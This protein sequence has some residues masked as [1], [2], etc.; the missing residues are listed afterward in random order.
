MKVEDVFINVGDYSTQ[1]YIDYA[2]AVTVSRAL[3]YVHDGLKPVHRRILYAMLGLGIKAKEKPKKSARI[4]GDVIGKYHPHGDG[5]VY[6]AMVGMAQDWN[7]RYPLVASQGNFGS[8]DGDGAAAMR[9]TEAG[10][11]PYAEEVLLSEIR[12]GTSDFTP[13]FDGSLTEVVLLSSKLNNLLLNGTFGIAVGMA[14]KIP[15]HNIRN[16][17]DATMAYI[18]NKDITIPE[19]VEHLQAPDFATGGQ[20]ITPKNKIIEAYETGR[21]A[22][23]IRCRWSVEKLPRGQWR[24]VVYELPPNQDVVKVLKTVDKITNPPVT[25]DKQGK[26]K[27]L[28]PNVLKDK[29]FLTSILSDATNQSDKDSLRLVL[30]PKSSK[31]DP[32]EFMS[33]LYARLG[34]EESFNFNLTMVDIN[35]TPQTMNI[36][37]IIA[38]W[39]EYRKIVVR[40]RLNFHLDKALR[41][42]HILEG[43]L[44]V[45]FNIDKAI[46]IIRTSEEPKEDLIEAFELSDIQAED[47]L[48][49]K[50]RQLA[51]L[52]KDKLEKEHAKLEA[53]KE[54]LQKILASEARFMTLIKKEIEET[55]K[56][57]EDDR[58]TIVEEAQEAIA[59]SSD[60][61]I[62]EPVTAIYTKYG[63]LTLRKGHGVD[64]STIALKDGDA[65]DKIIEGKTTDKLGFLATDGRGY[66]IKMIEVP[67]GKN[68]VHIKSLVDCGD[69]NIVEAM[70]GVKEDKY[71]FTN[72]SGYG[73]I[74]SAEN[75]IA[76]NKAGKHFMSM[77]EGTEVFKPLKF[78]EEMSRVNALTTDNRLLSFSIQEIKEL[79]KGKG[80]QIA[81]LK[82]DN[83]IKDISISHKDELPV[84]HKQ[85]KKIYRDEEL[86]PFN[87]KR[88]LRGKT[89]DEH[90]TLA[91]D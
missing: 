34:L 37:D 3:P 39:V 89:V 56:K 25:K 35:N 26:A 53:E 31:Q 85:K 90:T 74:S 24:V 10:L 41:R 28:T 70:L 9:Y 32:V 60:S 15:P 63:W 4:V 79:D 61:I 12:E 17:T 71:L 87:S 76:K 55:T 42:L 38:Q 67:S 52:E 66:S 36:K 50:L 77:P 69:A 57:F 22:V 7:M 21:G 75:L 29:Q 48:E 20:I 51:K 83:L 23:K 44:S 14:T 49:I 11:T 43:R 62:E 40:R 64:T 1:K 45:Y 84:Y 58:R 68:F 72:A 30:E 91:K 78:D 82:D 81:R 5:S 80:V 13:N 6:S 16:L 88:G 73:F 8:R 19:I 27:A 54:R 59:K 46:E 33:L 86:Q 47:I 65:I 2:V 18:E